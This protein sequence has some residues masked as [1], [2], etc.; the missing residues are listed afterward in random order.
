VSVVGIWN[1]GR[2]PH[3]GQRSCALLR[4]TTA[5]QIVHS[6]FIY[7]QVCKDQ[8]HP[9]L[10]PHQMADLAVRLVHFLGFTLWLGGLLATGLLLRAGAQAR[11]AAIVADAGATLSLLSGVYNAVTRSLLS[12]PWL[13]IKL[14][15]VAALL[16]V[17][18]AMRVRV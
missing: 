14:F 2:A 15:F 5:S 17:H 8:T 13:H 6:T 16:G 11:I 3:S 7:S 18:A 12:Q 10:C 4:G 1:T 9:V